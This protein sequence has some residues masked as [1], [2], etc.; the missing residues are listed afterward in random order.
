MVRDVERLPYGIA[1]RPAEV[2]LRHR[3]R[4]DDRAGVGE[5]GRRTTRQQ[6][7]KDVAVELG[8]KIHKAQFDRYKAALDNLIITDYLQF[9]FYKQGELV[10]RCEI[11][12]IENDKIHAKPQNFDTFSS[13]IQNF[14]LTVSQSIKSP[15]KLAQMMAAKAKLMADVIE[16][17]LNEDKENKTQSELYNQYE[18]FKTVLIHDISHAEFA[19]IYAQTIAY[20]MFAAR[21]HDETL[22][23]FTRQEAS[24]LIPQ[25][26]Y[27]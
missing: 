17:A 16:K 27:R 3:L 2:L 21:L 18:A 9:E 26:N 12:R 6:L 23:T 11:G 1:G 22:D 8:A 5:G 10:T 15:V 14:A 24:Q 4:Q 20:G 19:D 25:S 7:T 13:L